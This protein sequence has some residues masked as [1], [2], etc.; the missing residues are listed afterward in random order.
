MHLI[1]QLER[2]GQA[3]D[4]TGHAVQDGDLG[5]AVA[6]HSSHRVAETRKRCAIE[7]PASRGL[8]V[9]ARDLARTL[10]KVADHGRVRERI[11]IRVDEWGKLRGEQSGIGD[12]ARDDDIGPARDRGDESLSAEVGMRAEE[13]TCQ[14][15]LPDDILVPRQDIV[16]DHT[17]NLDPPNPHL[18]RQRRNGP[19]RRG[20]VRRAK[21]RDDPAPI[22]HRGRQERREPSAQTRIGSGNGI[23]SARAQPGNERPLGQAFENNG[24]DPA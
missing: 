17:R 4:A 20:R 13:R 2:A 12:P 7:L 16:S 1:K 11:P 18:T 19:R 6:G 10:E 22:G 8:E 9:P 24:V 21:V 5:A 15:S 3:V 23:L 14:W